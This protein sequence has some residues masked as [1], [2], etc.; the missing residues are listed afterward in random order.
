MRCRAWTLTSKTDRATQAPSRRCTHTT[1]SQGGPR[2]PRRGKGVFIDTSHPTF[3]SSHRCGGRVAHGGE[4][5]GFGGRPDAARR[6]QRCRAGV[7][8]KISAGS[9]RNA[10]P[11]RS[12]RA[13]SRPCAAQRDPRHPEKCEDLCHAPPRP[14]HSSGAGRGGSGALRSGP[15]QPRRRGRI[16]LWRARRDLPAAGSGQRRLPATAAAARISTGECVWR[17]SLVP[18]RPAGARVEQRLVGREPGTSVP[19]G[20]RQHPQRLAS[21]RQRR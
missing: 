10:L 6:R 8:A 21:N 7:G 2:G 20:L 17:A 3:D 13:D 1:S 15:H 19:N 12:G 18:G 9:V 16:P 14:E 4:P 11:Y 5:A